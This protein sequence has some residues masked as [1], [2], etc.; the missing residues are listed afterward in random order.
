MI[1]FTHRRGFSALLSTGWAAAILFVAAPASAQH[2]GPDAGAKGDDNQ[3]SIE[4]V[5][6]KTL[7]VCADEDP[8]CSDGLNFSAH[9]YGADLIGRGADYAA[10]RL[11]G[12]F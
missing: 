10:S 11:G 3:G 6:P 12:T 8:V 2:M 5:D 7:R 9:R 1:R 4:L